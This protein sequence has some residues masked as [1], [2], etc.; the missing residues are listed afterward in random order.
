V[1]ARS[2]DPGTGPETGQAADPRA[3]RAG[4]PE[5]TSGAVAGRP[6]GTSAP[7]A[8][9]DGDP[10][11]R[12]RP[13][14]AASW[15]QRLAL[16]G[17]WTGLVV[18]FAITE[19]GKFATVRNLESLFNTQSVLLI[20]AIAC[21]PP[22]LV[23]DLDLSTAATLALSEC[24]A[25]YLNVHFGWPIPAAIAVALG[26]GLLVGIANAGL[27]VG[28]GIDSI[29]V[30]LGMSTLVAGLALSIGSLPIPNLSAGWVNLVRTSF[31]GFQLAFYFA[32][33][34]ALV[35]WFVFSQTPLGRRMTFVG[36]GRNTAQLSGLR[37]RR[38][39]ATALIS[40]SLLSAVAGVLLAGLYGSAEATSGPQML[41]PALAAVF[42]GSTA[43]TPGRFNVPGTFV[44]VYFLV[45]GISGLEIAGITGW[46]S[47][48]FYGASLIVAVVL[49][50][51]GGL[52][53]AASGA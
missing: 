8:I 43:F 41:L 22:L 5:G 44:A 6:G 9:P 17:A 48:A 10:R 26:A 36:A 28:L 51:L 19:P 33:A 47:Q 42:L 38:L 52:R 46:V 34:V 25:G 13:Q 15:F 49:S 2:T 7:E 35:A 18:I 32:V 29:I 40:A 20:L 27:I 23:G 39:R 3:G 4:G 37:V 21:I 45:F 14:S 16:P 31:F 11:L 53:R 12:Y 30:T 24:I 1:T 50:R